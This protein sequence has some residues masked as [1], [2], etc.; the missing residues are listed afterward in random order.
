MKPEC[1]QNMFTISFK[2]IDDLDSLEQMSAEQFD[3][4]KQDI[5]GMI[6]LD[7]NGSTYG[8]FF[9]DCPFGNERLIRWFVDLLTVAQMV[10]VNP[11]VAY[12]IPDSAHLWLEFKAHGEELLVSLVE[13][14]DREVV[15]DL[16][17]TEPLE[18]FKYSTWSGV[19]INLESFVKEIIR[20]TH[21]FLDFISELNAKLL[22]SENVARI[23]EKLSDLEQE[24]ST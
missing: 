16:F 2:A 21:L 14:T 1:A 19:S 17:I 7:F 9:D 22:K 12:R 24:S 11:Y 23:S 8:M 10:S 18:E 20:N 6:E 3:Q 15:L 13:D 5:D 4:A